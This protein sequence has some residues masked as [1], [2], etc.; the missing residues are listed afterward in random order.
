MRA[1]ARPGSHGLDRLLDAR[2]TKGTSFSE[3]EREALGLTGLL[4]HAVETTQRRVERVLGHLAHKPDDLERYVYLAALLDRDEALFYRTVMADPTR[5]LPII[6]A[7]T[8]GEACLKFDQIY[9]RPRGMYVTLE[10]R[11]RIADVLRNWPEPEVRFICVTTGG[12]ILGLGDI[13]TNGMGIAIGKLQCYTVCAGVPPTV[14]LPLLLDIGTTNARLRADPLYLGL[15]QAPPDPPAL[16]AFVDEFVDAVQTVFPDACLHFEDWKG[17]DAQRYLAR[18]RDRLPCFNDDIQ[19]TAAIVLAGLISAVRIR[20]E[21]LAA[22]RF[23]LFGAG[24]AGMGIAEMLVSALVDQGLDADA[25]HACIHLFDSHGLIHAGRDHVTPPQRCFAH[26]GAQSESLQ[27]AVEAI[28]PTVLIGTSAVADAFNEASIRAM[29][30]ATARPIVFAL[31]NP[32]D[33]AEITAENA[34]RWT[35]GQALFAA[36]VQFPDVVVGDRALRPGQ[37]NNVFVFPA[38]GLATYATRPRTLPDD[39]FIAAA[40]AIADQVASGTAGD[41]ALFPAQARV[42]ES[43]ITTATRVAERIFDLGLAGVERP[44][45]LRAWVEAFVYDPQREPVVCEPASHNVN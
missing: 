10:H 9:R 35:D 38:I 30:K 33:H 8:I 43:A 2:A 20:R 6:Y 40:H 24:A 37:A 7:P 4:P 13:G 34:Y 19:G 11:G 15:R 28:A 29:A 44:A 42:F 32:T 25:A 14:S 3:A 16:D 41:D 26:E 27:A 36:G 12:R 17:S 39:L 45:D 1:T 22:Q 21:T 23:L 5:F 18:Y 31:S